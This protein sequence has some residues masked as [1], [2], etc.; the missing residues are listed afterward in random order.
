MEVHVIHI[1]IKIRIRFLCGIFVTL[2]SLYLFGYIIPAVVYSLL[3]G[4]KACMQHLKFQGLY[5]EGTFLEPVKQLITG[6]YALGT[7]SHPVI[8]ICQ[9]VYPLFPVIFS[10]EFLQQL[11]LILDGRPGK[12]LEFVL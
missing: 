5:Y 12:L 4:L 10:G 11:D 2:N 1:G 8:Q 6:L 7:K 3:F 9:L